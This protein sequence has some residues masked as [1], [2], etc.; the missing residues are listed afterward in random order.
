MYLSINV[1]IG[2]YGA[3]VSKMHTVGV[4]VGLWP[5]TYL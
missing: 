5:V 3:E 1:Y 4:G 2:N